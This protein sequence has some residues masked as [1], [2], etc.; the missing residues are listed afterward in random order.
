MNVARLSNL[1]FDTDRVRGAS[2]GARRH[3]RLTQSLGVRQ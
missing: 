1:T 2:Y 3:G